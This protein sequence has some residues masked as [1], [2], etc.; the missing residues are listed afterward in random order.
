[1][2]GKDYGGNSCHLLY[3]VRTEQSC[4]RGCGDTNLQIPVDDSINMA[5]MDTLQDLLYAVAE[6]RRA[7]NEHRIVMEQM[8]GEIRGRWR[9]KMEVNSREKKRKRSHYN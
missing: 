3:R 7:M 6:G 8:E 5:V 1:M 4:S 9:E 2:Q